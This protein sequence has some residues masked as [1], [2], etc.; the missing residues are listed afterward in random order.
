VIRAVTHAASRLDHWLQ[1]K[2]GRPYNVVLGVGLTIE[3]VR[4]VSEIPERLAHPHRLIPLLLLLTLEGALLIHQ[5]GEL[6]DF[7]RPRGAPAKVPPAPD[8]P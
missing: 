6:S 1:A 5:V 4:R 8:Q 2:L 3:I 7:V